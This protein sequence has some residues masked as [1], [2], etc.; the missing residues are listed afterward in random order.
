MT[1]QEI[2]DK[3]KAKAE[4]IIEEIN[5]TPKGWELWLMVRD[6]E[7]TWTTQTENTYSVG[8]VFSRWGYQHSKIV[9]WNDI[10][11]ELWKD[12]YNSRGGD[13]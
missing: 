2:F 5:T 13:N 3:C 6:N 4:A 9:G 8:P 12:L 11:T 1:N 7:V 10:A